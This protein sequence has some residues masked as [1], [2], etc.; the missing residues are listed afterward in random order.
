MGRHVVNE[1]FAVILKCDVCTRS[2]HLNYSGSIQKS[3]NVTSAG[4]LP[5][6]WQKF[7]RSSEN[8]TELFHFLA[9]GLQQTQHEK[10][11]I[12]TKGEEV[13]SDDATDT[14]SLKSTQE[15]ADTR[16]LLHLFHAVQHGHINVTIRTVD[17]DVVVIAISLYEE[18]RKIQLK[19]LWISFGVGK[20][21]NVIA[22]HQLANTIGPDRCS[23]MMFFHAF[24][25]CDTVSGFSGKGK[26]SFWKAWKAMPEVTH[27]FKE[28]SRPVNAV[29]IRHM[30]VLARFVIV[31]YDIASDLTDIDQERKALFMKGRAMERLPPTF[32]ALLQHTKRS[33]LQAG[34]IWGQSW[35]ANPEY[36]DFGDWGWK[37][38]KDG[39]WT[40]LWTTKKETLASLKELTKCSCRSCNK[41]RCACR[42]SGLPC[43]GLCKCGGDFCDS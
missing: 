30:D 20:A 5:K 40:P 37:R 10:T 38:E 9:D 41:G 39:V 43:T 8:K 28:L 11:I 29:E 24:T 13:L 2:Y 16:L 15:E 19:K 3:K 33:C 6:N 23:G 34:Y 4:K 36:P 18:L 14:S 1:G 21:H 42:K 27:V 32:D 7:L 31:A 17:T 35:I 12:A 22:V 25:G 26:K